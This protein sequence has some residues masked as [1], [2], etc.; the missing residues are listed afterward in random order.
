MTRPLII[1]TGLIYAYIAAES[2]FKGNNALAV[3]YAGYAL[4]NVGLWRL[5]AQ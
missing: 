1:L 5:A 2:C 3:V 4:A